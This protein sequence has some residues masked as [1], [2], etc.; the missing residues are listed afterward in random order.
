MESGSDTHRQ[1][2]ARR[3]AELSV[4][5]RI[6]LE[7][8]SAEINDRRIVANATY[9]ELELESRSVEDKKISKKNNCSDA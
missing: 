5:P 6:G 2:N 3:K 7:E 1:I 9:S 8:S 4:S